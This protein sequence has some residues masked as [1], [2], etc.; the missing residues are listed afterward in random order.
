MFLVGNGLDF[1]LRWDPRRN[2]SCD[3]NLENGKVSADYE[4]Y[5]SHALGRVEVRARPNV[6]TDGIVAG[7]TF[8]SFTGQ[9]RAAMVGLKIF[10]DGGGVANVIGFSSGKLILDTVE[11]AMEIFTR[12]CG[13]ARH[14]DATVA[15]NV[16][17]SIIDDVFEVGQKLKIDGA[18]GTRT[19]TSI[20]TQRQAV[21]DGDP[22]DSSG[23]DY[24]VLVN[25]LEKNCLLTNEQK[26][27]TLDTRV[28][29]ASPN[30][31][32]IIWRMT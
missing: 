6:Y 7:N 5:S 27:R 21:F 25:T 32:S 14:H 4:D 1:E 15:G 16:I 29:E 23:T 19:I 22:H 18:D 12:P 20:Q 11:Q 2:N 3:R 31:T 9:L 28:V 24:W 30:S 26:T 13:W 8:A 17:E 10:F